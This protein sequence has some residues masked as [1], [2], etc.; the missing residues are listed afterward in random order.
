MVPPFEQAAFSLGIGAVSDLVTS[1]FGFH[2]IKVLEKQPARTQK[3]EEVANLIRPTLAQRKAEQLAQ[4]L[5]D[6]A[7]SR[8]KSNQTLEQIATELK[9]E[10][11]ET[12]FFAPGTDVP[13]VGN[14]PDFSS[15]VF[16]LK[17]KEITSPVRIPMGYIIAQLLEIKAP[18]LPE[19]AEV[20][21]KVEQ[22]FKAVKSVEVARNKAQDFASKVKSGANFDA[23]AKTFGGAVKNSDAFARK[24]SLPDL[25][26]TEPLDGFAFAG[27]VGDI[28]QPIAV[29]QKQVVLQLKEKFAIN[30]ES[31]AKEKNS[32]RETLESQRKDQ[33]F[34]AYLDEAKNRLMKTGKIKIN[35]K[36]FDDISR[37]L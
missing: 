19:L 11:H 3:Y 34:Q 37:R 32:L 29:G 6:K 4:D 15:K 16:S 24:G 20:H 31:F 2:I 28:S 13:M 8:I 36:T 18:Y 12:P 14:T 1:Q 27:K 26:S 25:G 10:L 22:D 21:P 9:L 5:S 17:P 7:Y 33:V 30:P 35:Q 23:T